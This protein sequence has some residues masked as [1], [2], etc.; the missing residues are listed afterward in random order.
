[1]SELVSRRS[2]GGVFHLSFWPVYL[3]ASLMVMIALSRAGSNLFWK[4]SNAEPSGERAAPL[5]IAIV[6]VLLSCTP[7]MVIFAG[8]I[9]E[10]TLAAAAQLHDV[11]GHVNAVIGVSLEGQQ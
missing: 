6:I 7:L 10:F 9:S 3:L 5:Q 11:E 1:M 8:P 2:L 4:Q